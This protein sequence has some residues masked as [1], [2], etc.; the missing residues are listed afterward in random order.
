MQ[1]VVFDRLL[2]AIEDCGECIGVRGQPRPRL[3][4]GRILEVRAKHPLLIDH[5]PLHGQIIYLS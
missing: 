1:P 3:A 4:I 5:F 2:D